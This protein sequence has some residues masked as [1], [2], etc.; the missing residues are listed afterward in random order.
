MGEKVLQRLNSFVDTK[1]FKDGG[2]IAGQAVA[3]AL[4]EVYGDGRGVVYNDVDYFRQH[5]TSDNKKRV[6]RVLEM[7]AIRQSSLEVRYGQLHIASNYHYRVA[8]TKR[9]DML[10]EV[11]CFG[12]GFL[13]GSN[14]FL[15]TDLDETRFLKSFDLNCVQ[16][17]V[18]VRT[19]KLVWTPAFERFHQTREMLVEN[20]RTPV[21]SAIRYFR[22]KKELEGVYGKDE[23]IM[24]Q[25]SCQ[26]RRCLKNHDEASNRFSMGQLYFG[27]HYHGKLQDV[28]KE[29][30][31]WMNL[32]SIDGQQIDLYTLQP[33]SDLGLQSEQEELIDD[34]LL[35]QY[36][37]A[38]QGFWKKDVCSQI[39]NTIAKAS[40]I[41]FNI[42]FT[43]RKS[44]MET[45]IAPMA[46]KSLNKLLNEHGMNHW[47]ADMSLER[48]F[49]FH[50]ALKIC[51]RK[52]GVA[53]YGI[54]ETNSPQ[55]IEAQAGESYKD[56]A[57][58]V[59][60]CLHKETLNLPMPSKV[61]SNIRV[62]NGFELRQLSS[63]LELLEEGVRQHHCVGGYTRYVGDGVSRIVSLR[64]RKASETV[65]IELGRSKFG[66][67]VE[68][69]KGFGN[70]VAGEDA[71]LPIKQTVVAISLADYLRFLPLNMR[72]K[73]VEQVLRNSNMT[74][75]LHRLFSKCSP[76]S[77]TLRMRI[78]NLVL[79]LFKNKRV[80]FSD[81]LLGNTDW[82]TYLSVWVLIIFNVD[83]R[84][85]N[86]KEFTDIPF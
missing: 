65:T 81:Y 36:F 38:K 86:T 77:E 16:V 19:G 5:K 3:S 74:D 31:P 20:M 47:I 71:C 40:G 57:I 85:T 83:I 62:A 48:M 66:W 60:D 24:E 82:A 21:H 22:K 34:G 41:E 45:H 7:D 35:T 59:I 15:L 30:A 8:S 1:A 51:E 37:R 58:R 32:Q 12:L 76:A 39:L 4:S 56:A 53:V 70:D 72:T 55:T 54:I 42:L 50:D 79:R 14:E 17:G 29:L 75:R 43:D 67:L 61:M 73:A 46:L 23:F 11:I 6:G 33:R 78:N 69:A 2:M 13:G 68:Q 27:D 9:L 80:Y 10:N 26:I 52:Y 25:L 63:A 18:S 44:S 84:S 64:K 28:Q 49:E